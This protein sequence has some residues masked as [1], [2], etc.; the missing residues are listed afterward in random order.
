MKKLYIFLLGLSCFSGFG[1]TETTGFETPNYAP[2]TPEAAA[3]LKYGEYPVDLSTGVPNI[4]IP[5]YT[6]EDNG[7]K[8]PISL[9]YHAGGIKVNQEATWVG[10]G[11]NL[12]FGAQII[13]SP[14]D[15]IDE[16]NPLIDTEIDADSIHE[17]FDNHP[18][19]F[20]TGIIGQYQLDKS[21][22]RDVYNFSSP[23]V[24]GNFYIRNFQENDVVIFPPDAFKVELIGT[25]R[26][27][28]G[29]KI[30]DPAGNSYYFTSTKEISER[31]MTHGDDY[32]SAWYVDQI[33]TAADN[34]ITFNYSD[35]GQINDYSFSQ[36]IAIKENCNSCG[37][38]DGGVPQHTFGAL[39]TQGGSTMTNAKKIS[40][41]VFNG[42]ISKVIFVAQTGREDLIAGNKKLNRI[43]VKHLEEGGFALKSGYDFSYGY[44]DA[45]YGSTSFG[46]KNKRLKLL[47]IESVFGGSKHEFKYS[48]VDVPAKT[49]MAVDYFGYANNAPNFNMI[50]RHYISVP[51]NS[52]IGNANRKVNPNANQ[53]GMLEEIHYPTKGWTKF[54]Y[55]TN[56]YFGIDQLSK[57][58][59]ISVSS[60]TIQGG[61]FAN[62]DP[63]ITASGE[64]PMCHPV[65]SQG[66]IN[67]EI[68]NFQAIN[69]TGV[70]HVILTD[71][72]AS[73]PTGGHDR[74]FRVVLECGNN[75]LYDSFI[76]GGARLVR[77]VYISGISLNGSG[78]LTV[79]AYGSSMRAYAQLIFTNND[80][81]PKNLNGG[82][83][84]IASIQSFNHDN[85]PVTRKDFSYVDPSNTTKTSG[86]AVNSM[87][88]SFTSPNFTSASIAAC[89]C[90]L[91]PCGESWGS[92][93]SRTYSVSSNSRYGIESNTVMYEYVQEREINVNDSLS[94]GLTK[95]K[96]LLSSDEIPWGD[97]IVTLSTSWKR[98]KLLEK[99][100]FK[101][102]GN[103]LQILLKETNV[104]KEDTLAIARI[105]GFKFFRRG[106]FSH[107]EHPTDPFLAPMPFALLQG[108][109]G[110]PTNVFSIYEIAGYNIPAPWFYL[111][112]TSTEEYFYDGADNLIDSLSTN[113]TYY[114]D[115]PQ[116][117]QMT[118]QSTKNSK[119]QTLETKYSYAEDASMSGE[120][121]IATLINKYMIG[122][123][124]K[125]ESFNGS[126]KLAGKKTIFA[127]DSTT[128][129]IL[130]PKIIQTSKGSGA[131]ETEITY[132]KYDSDGTLIQYRIK[133]GMVV[134]LLWDYNNVNVSA[135]IENMA[136]ENIPAGLV[137]ALK[138]ASQSGHE[139][140]LFT[141]LNN[142]R[143][144]P[145]LADAMVTTYTY[146]A[147]IGVSS[148]T[149]PKGIIT[150]Y[151][152]D[153]LGRLIEIKD[154]DGNLLKEN[155][156]HFKN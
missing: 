71:D 81:A 74:Y 120:P 156:Y 129:N 55:E 153:G 95:Y 58:D 121:Q 109:F 23:T 132:E 10:L 149:D 9:N 14:R 60:S 83:L 37:C 80:T 113:K 34:V 25:S 130:L 118:R 39:D 147:L 98:G 59:P 152:Y 75:I 103:N 1:Q 31:T 117:L 87:I 6:I 51:Y 38:P 48:D 19:N 134:T 92:N 70:L 119:G 88:T 2:K 5:I 76:T 79:E 69:A 140:P 90:N 21:R 89:P 53:F 32:T 93:Y 111:K 33:K 101:K 27:N 61:G 35:D 128:A 18:Y 63:P 114:Y 122:I 72:L 96:Y 94:K 138:L 136:Y 24:T 26:S 46:Y 85:T 28:M 77:D 54:N 142:L 137:S 126:T 47:S 41:I 144:D 36:S 146:D 29:F 124:L 16:N 135:K 78:S 20:N 42:G 97:P 57:Y 104:Y 108:T 133:N 8:I 150:N 139:A 44:F 106:S 45:D 65:S 67:G 154:A 73:D 56:Q 145:A 11:W 143:N 107:L 116:H 105:E 102:Q 131:L 17:Y 12:N 100:V 64:Y 4:S 22:V 151:K 50:P 86:R 68:T 40:S 66:C 99:E 15:D 52:F 112:Q 49:S 62:I 84:R 91:V 155:E 7:F 127:K 115:N 141:A 3:F 110:I 148:I 82:G 123:P 30:T 13:L 125:V 43:E